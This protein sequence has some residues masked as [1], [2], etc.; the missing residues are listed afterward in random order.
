MSFA[1]IFVLGTEVFPTEVRG[2]AMG[3]Q[4]SMARLGGIFASAAS[5]MDIYFFDGFALALFAGLALASAIAIEL[6]VPET[7]GK[8]M[9]D[10]LL[11]MDTG[12]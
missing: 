4:N 2:T 8:K 7:L 9:P 6:V 3:N 1:I 10:T 11:E 12:T 5:G